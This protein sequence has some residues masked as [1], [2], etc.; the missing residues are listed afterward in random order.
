MIKQIIF[1]SACNE[2]VLIR[3]H[4]DKVV[5]FKISSIKNIKFPIT[6][7]ALS[8]WIMATGFWNDTDYWDDFSNWID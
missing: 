8:N 5:D 6:V 7:T 1:Y 3:T 4:I 2:N